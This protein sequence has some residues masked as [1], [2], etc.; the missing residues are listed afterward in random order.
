MGS[1]KKADPAPRRRG[2]KVSHRRRV[3]LIENLQAM[4]YDLARLESR[5]TAAENM[6]KRDYWTVVEIGHLKRFTERLKG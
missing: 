6:I 1:K 2:M 5:I 3:E 4:R